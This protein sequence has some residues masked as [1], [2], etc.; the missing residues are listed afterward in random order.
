MLNVRSTFAS[1]IAAAEPDVA[2]LIARIATAERIPKDAA[3]SA[4]TAKRTA[5][6]PIR[7]DRD[8]GWRLSDWA[9]ESASTWTRLMR[10]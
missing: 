1:N 2:T 8:A 10:M 6:S 9:M 4:T 3:T 5:A 7:Q